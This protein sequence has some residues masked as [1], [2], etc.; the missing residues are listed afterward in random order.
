MVNKIPPYSLTRIKNLHI[1]RLVM[2]PTF[3][4]LLSVLYI[5]TFVGAVFV[6]LIAAIS[7][8]CSFISKQHFKT[9]YLLLPPVFDCWTKP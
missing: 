2:I 4:I 6:A 5:A 3:A 8:F 1:R 7:E 9:I